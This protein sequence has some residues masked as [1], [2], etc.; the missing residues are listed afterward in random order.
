MVL[1]P[2]TEKMPAALL[3]PVPVKAIAPV[4]VVTM[5]GLLVRSIP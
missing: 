3:V 1:V 2:V 5:D 4:P